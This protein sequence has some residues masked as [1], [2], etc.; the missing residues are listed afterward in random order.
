MNLSPRTAIRKKRPVLLNPL[1]T[2][3]AHYEQA[4]QGHLKAPLDVWK[5]PIETAGLGSLRR[6]GRRIRA[7]VQ[8]ISFGLSTRP[9]ITIWPTFGLA[10]LALARLSRGDR[11][12]IIHDPVPLRKQIGYGL[13]G[14]L[15]GGWG[16]RGSRVQ[17]VA[18]TEL[19][20]KALRSQGV[21]VHVIL[22][23]PILRVDGNHEPAQRDL[24]SV[25]VAGQFKSAR[26]L[27]L[28]AQLPEQ[29]GQ[30]WD[31][32]VCGR[33]WPEISGWVVDSRFLSE[34]ELDQAI[35]NAGVVLLPYT[36]YFQSGIAARAFELGTPVVARRHEF[37]EQLF[38]AEW[39][40]LVE[41]GD[42]GNWTAVL[43]AVLASSPSLPASTTETADIQWQDAVASLA[44]GPRHDAGHSGTLAR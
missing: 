44:A 16:S 18:H 40:G 9:I 1:P 28:L 43:Q 35:L 23:H 36:H 41:T 31:L 14:K 6:L 10:E 30:N 4:L 24:D 7:C 15:L 20:A 21:R 33:G 5:A 8:L 27:S 37:I 12:V 11:L 13:P 25:L 29:L 3:M 38:G 42:I 32:K 22:P 17:V 19:A 2:A 39:A 26:D 34:A